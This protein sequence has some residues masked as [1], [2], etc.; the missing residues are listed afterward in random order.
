MRPRFALLALI[1]LAAAVGCRPTPQPPASGD[2]TAVVVS[3]TGITDSLAWPTDDVS[4]EPDSITQADVDAL[5][6]EVA[7]LRA[8][9][10]RATANPSG[11]AFGM[12]GYLTTEWCKS[13]TAINST[14]MT[15]EPKY[16]RAILDAA[17]AC[18]FRFQAFYARK[19]ETTNGVWNGPYSPTKNRQL[20]DAYAAALPPT[21]A[22]SY[23][24][25][26]AFLGYVVLD[27]MG[28][29]T[30][31]GGVSISQQT[32]AEALKYAQAKLGTVPIGLRVHP[33]WMLRNGAT[34][35]TWAMPDGSSSVDYPISMYYTIFSTQKPYPSQA[36]WYANQ[37]K[38][39]TTLGI[40]AQMFTVSFGGCHKGS[41]S[42]GCPADE[43]KRMGLIANA[44]PNNCANLGWNWRSEFAKEPHLSVVRA[45]AADAASRPTRQCWG[46]L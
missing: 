18:H 36:Q 40:P 31:W 42:D 17:V 45:L 39:Q 2:S 24:D 22:K 33:E 14:A 8:S 23:V 5:T 27:D 29:P 11:L 10:R 43:M 21:L 19:L 25:K 4:H 44:Q 1:A 37:V 34:R 30:S 3:D 7:V 13:G 46:V 20:T 15:I 38:A 35:A 26:G 9:G 32:T 6:A 16:L 12:H 28:S 41:V